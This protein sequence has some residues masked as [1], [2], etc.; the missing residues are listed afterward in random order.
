MRKIAKFRA[1]YSIFGEIIPV[2]RT[3]NVKRLSYYYKLNVNGFSFVRNALR[4]NT[5]SRLK[6][7]GHLGVPFIDLSWMIRKRRKQVNCFLAGP[8]ELLNKNFSQTPK[9]IRIA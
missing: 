2:R 1:E 6:R 3:N 7:N 8:T 9:F 4:P 5:R